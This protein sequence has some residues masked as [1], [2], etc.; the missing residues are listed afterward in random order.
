MDAYQKKLTNKDSEIC[1]S[2]AVK[3]LTNRGT[4]RRR[5]A[6]ITHEIWVTG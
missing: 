2:G 6:V 4:K 1:K 3:R 5:T